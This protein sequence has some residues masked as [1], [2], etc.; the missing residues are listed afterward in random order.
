[1][2][3]KKLAIICA[4]WEQLP[5]VEKAKEMGIET[6]CFAW[7]KEGY[8]D[9]KGVADFFHPIS[10]LEKEQILKVCKDIKIDGITSCNND[11]AI[12]TVAYVAENMGLIGNRYA[13]TMITS[14]DKYESRQAMFK[15]GV[16][17]PRFVVAREGQVPNLNGFK[18][19]LIVKPVDRSGSVGVMKV[20]TEAELHEAIL[21]AQQLS[22]SG[23]AI[24][25]EFII[26]VEVSVESISWNGIHYNLA[27]T[28]KVTTNEPYHVEIAH[29]EPS[30][31][32]EEIQEKVKTEAR[33]ALTAVNYNYGASDTEIKITDN[34]DVYIIEVNARLGGDFTYEMVK[35]STGYD[36]LKG[37]IDVALNQ[38]EVPVLIEHMYS[39]IYYLCK[40]NEWV[41]HVIENK[42]NYPEITEAVITKEE[43]SLIQYSGDR[44]GYF[45]YKSDRKMIREE[46]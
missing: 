5:L 26:G 11:L 6:H 27:L 21:R 18:Y 14:N 10:I 37:V 45:I 19:P 32:S 16:N 4:S 40:E 38:F 3:K 23:K 31:L 29:H 8:T 13:D 42:E 41:K 17:S 24:I 33:K 34:G 1:M 25:E 20:D 35:L 43:L 39:G 15:N 2:K 30:E 36:F 9:C 44:S 7:D 12:S 22:Y 28:D 46:F